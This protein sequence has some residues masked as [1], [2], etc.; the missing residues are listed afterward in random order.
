MP[1]TPPPL[2]LLY[3]YHE[4]TTG[5]LV[6]RGL[7]A[8]GVPCFAVGP[9]H[10]EGE[11]SFPCGNATPLGEIL[12]TLRG[13]FEPTGILVME[14]G[15]KFFPMGLETSPLPL[16]YYAIDSHFN[17]P[18]QL[19]YIKL[20]DGVLVAFRQ[21][22][23]SFQQTGHPS[24]HWL[25]HAF[26]QTFYQD[27]GLE[28]EI[29]VAFVGDMD[30]D[31]RPQRVALLRALEA[32]GLTVHFTRGIWNEAVGRL[33]SR[34]R[35]VFN[36]NDHGV[37][38]PRNFEASACGAVVLSNPAH[39][40][41]HFFRPG[42]EILIYH[43]AD[44]LVA[45][46]RNALADPARW[47]QWS[48]NAKAVA[49]RHTWTRRVEHLLGALA[50]PPTPS[51]FSLTEKL[52]AHAHVYLQRGLPGRTVEITDHLI[53]RG[54]ADAETWL[55]KTLAYYQNGFLREAA[56]SLRGLLAGVPAPPL[57]ASLGE[58][59][60]TIFEQAGDGL[61]AQHLL[62]QWADAP[63]SLRIRLGRLIHPGEPS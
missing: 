57:L 4:G 36:D 1:A 34:A 3:G 15:V 49:A 38:N 12:E 62:E 60:T 16:W 10:P 48:A 21:Y 28:R 27:Y 33:Y 2:L 26:D 59:M 46:A 23:P 13:R 35:L 8:N 50:T 25:P 55:I 30:P 6:E 40:L 9:G 17:L 39:D 56:E 20:F 32:S 44:E 63:Q 51:P 41:E 7:R 45:H 18:W 52:K 61:G 42:E 29:D 53:A 24:L 11:T 43:D 31:N 47:R 22:I 37:F 54:G 14:S 58:L 5:S 19:E